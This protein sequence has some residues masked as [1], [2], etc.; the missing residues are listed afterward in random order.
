MVA[1]IFP[2][3]TDILALTRRHTL[4][5]IGGIDAKAAVGIEPRSTE[6]PMSVVGASRVAGE[7]AS[8]HAIPIG[9]RLIS[10]VML[11]G[12]INLFVGLFNFIPLLPL[13]GGHILGALYEGLRRGIARLFK[14][15]DPGY[16][17]V[18]KLL[19]VAYLMAGVILVADP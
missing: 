16:F 2:E 4:K 14:R 1:T 3:K 19:P 10:L 5:S 11:L 17:D 13:D 7:V 12:A 9:D 8:N 15:P 18:A 6:S